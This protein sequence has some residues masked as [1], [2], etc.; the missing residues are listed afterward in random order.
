MLR[1]F[2]RTRHLSRYREIIQA[3]SKYGFS[4][5][6]TRFGL[7]ERLSLRRGGDKT[8]T[9]IAQLTA[10]ERLRIALEE[11]GPT[12]IKLG[13]ILSTR[14]DFIPPEYITEL[15]K[16]QDRAPQIAWD[17]I[18]AIIET[19][20]GKSSA[21]VF[22]FIE[23]EPLAAASL[24]QVH[25]ASLLDGSS[26]VIKVQRP[27]IEEQI[28]IDLEI[29]HDV[30]RLIQAVSPFERVYDLPA[31][32]EE[33]AY[34]LQQELDFT[35]EQRNAEFFREN[36]YGSSEVYIPKVYAQFTT[37]RLLVLERLHG[38][39]VDNI[40]RLEQV[41]YDRHELAVR[42]ARLVIKEI[43]EDG[44]FH[45]D[46]HPGNLLVLSGGMIGVMDFGMVGWL[47]PNLRVQI[48]QLYIS[49]VQ[50]DMDAAV[51][52]LVQLNI[53]REDVDRRQ[54]HIDLTRL[55]RKYRG[56]RLQHIRARDLVDDITEIVFRYHLQLPTEL[57]L[58]LKTL[59]IIEGVGLRLDP[60][61]DIFSESKPFVRKLARQQFSPSNLQNTAIRT[62]ININELLVTAPELL[63]RVERGDLKIQLEI[64]RLDTLFAQIS[65]LVNRITVTIL[66]SSMILGVSFLLPRLEN[67]PIWF[68]GFVILL[69][70][71]ASLMGLW[72]AW[73]TIRNRRR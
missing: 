24:A 71:F 11:L 62:S 12:F 49:I 23:S 56:R 52:K 2:Q 72:L 38:I 18:H 28:E 22:R 35:L 27:H 33:F 9:N 58:L 31:I 40:E 48:A 39:K 25:R 64:T 29:L 17:E 67:A 14:P 61:F 73:T 26:V 21:E 65:V 66:I 70:V 44:F 41:G 4:E 8:E 3:F 59:V 47:A 55:I 13:Q 5:F 54:L 10:P 42:S 1:P 68:V 15:E 51:A 30:A 63:R 60:N 43:L 45:A 32:A 16:L 7:W 34:T 19:E 69:F 6:V 57:W 50:G 46:P 53:A 20:L 36:F 37:K